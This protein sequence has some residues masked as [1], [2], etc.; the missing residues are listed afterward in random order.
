MA[1]RTVGVIADKNTSSF[2]QD[3]TEHL[4]KKN[5]VK[6]KN[7][8]KLKKGQK[9]EKSESK[10]TELHKKLAKATPEQRQTYIDKGVI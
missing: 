4:K 9:L 10:V 3:Y 7:N 6:K 2:S 5:T 1:N 8:L